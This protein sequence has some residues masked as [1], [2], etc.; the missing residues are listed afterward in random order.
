MSANLTNKT[1]HKKSNSKPDILE[2]NNLRIDLESIAKKKA[3]A[4][5]F[6]VNVIMRVLDT[7]QINGRLKR[8]NLGGRAGLS[9]NK[10]NRF[11]NYK[12]HRLFSYIYYNTQF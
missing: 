12:F 3:Y 5:T 1:G 8:T 2:P 11:S 7:L 9:Y 10:C 6:S 4:T